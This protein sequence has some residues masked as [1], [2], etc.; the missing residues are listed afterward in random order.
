[1][2]IFKVWNTTRTLKK[3]VAASS[4]NDLKEKGA[5]KL[6]LPPCSHIIDLTVVLEEDGTVI[7]EDEILLSPELSGSTLLLLLPHETWTAAPK[8]P[9]TP[10]QSAL[11]TLPESLPTTST[12]TARQECP[13][14]SRTPKTLIDAGSPSDFKSFELC[15]ALKAAPLP[16]FSPLVEREL[17][18]EKPEPLKVWT[19]MI[20][21]TAHFYLGKWPEIGE[22]SHYRIIGEKMFRRFPC[23]G[24]DGPTQWSAFNKSLSQKIRHIRCALK[25][26]SQPQPG[27]S[28]ETPPTKKRCFRPL[29]FANQQPEEVSAEDVARHVVELGKECEKQKSGQSPSHIKALLK[30]TRQDRVEMLVKSPEG[31][32]SAITKKYPCL[33]DGQYVLFE[34]A[35]MMGN[36]RV[37]KVATKVRTLLLAVE[38]LGEMTP[39]SQNDPT[40]M[41]ALIEFIEGKTKFYQGG[42]RHIK[43]TSSIVK[44][45][46]DAD[47]SKE[48]QTKKCQAPYIVAFVSGST[49]TGLFIV[50]DTVYIE[51]DINDGLSG[52]LVKLIACYYIFDLDYPRT[53]A[54]LLAIL[55][56]HVM[57]EPYHH[58]KSK[59]FII[60]SK[61]LRDKIKE[62]EESE[63]E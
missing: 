6:V 28:N 61:I 40:R 25:K 48:L 50:A 31:G 56:E 2:P 43:Q 22:Q 17:T 9:S 12:A 63:N 29:D 60:F 35:L 53:Y 37:R 34:F 3:A 59:G 16:T 27:S 8:M 49:L 21:Q 41:L 45:V 10:T 24:F 32:I 42:G 23:I 46:A 20:K 36:E 52:S 15:Q 47:I 11:Q 18:A 62:L 58:K 14:T 57:G 44:D 7:D 38:A 19:E 30:S 51:L 33:T 39:T 5:Q 54:M 13:N 4:L 55:Q 26:K 1:M